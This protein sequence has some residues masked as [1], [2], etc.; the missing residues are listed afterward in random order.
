MIIEIE[1]FWGDCLLHG[2]KT[3]SMTLQ[4]QM[5]ALLTYTDTKDFVRIF[6]VRYGYEEL[7][8]DE[9]V[10]VDYVMDLDI[11]RIYRPRY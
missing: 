2:P 8:F 7:P 5:N 10:R 11:S 9:T 6:C 4:S 3:D 1:S